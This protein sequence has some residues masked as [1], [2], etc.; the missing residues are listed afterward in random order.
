VV[1]APYYAIHL[2]EYVQLS[3][4]ATVSSEDEWTQAFGW[5]FG[6]ARRF[7]LENYTWYLWAGIN[8]QYLVPLL[9]FLVVGLGVALSEVKRRPH[10]LELL[11]GLLIGY[12]AMTLLAVHDPR[13]TLPLV[14]Y[15]AVLATGWITMLPRVWRTVGIVAV[16]GVVA[17]N[18]AAGTFGLLE[19]RKITMSGN[20]P[21]DLIHPGAFTFV[22][23]RGYVVGEP[24]PDPFWEQLMEGMQEEGLQKVQL[25]VLETPTWGTD[26]AGF[27]TFAY[28]HDI[29]TPL[30]DV[31]AGQRPDVVATMW[32]TSDEFYITQRGFDPP[33]AAIE[34][35]VWNPQAGTRPRD[36]GIP[37]SVLVERRAP[38]GEL[39]RW[40]DFA[41]G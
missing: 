14:V 27:E 6:G 5:T 17:V 11:A 26:I 19:T 18:T 28:E 22:D 36:E 8:T 25:V 21:A 33:C 39:E 41:T 20:D 38:D 4:E 31:E 16:A 10:L 23:K 7:E 13:Y 37:V 29:S 2:S 3:K 12:L 34:E 35:G 24:R 15:V 9:G 32:W 40:C 1:A 30:F